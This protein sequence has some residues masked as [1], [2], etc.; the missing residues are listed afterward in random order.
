MERA[1]QGDRGGEFAIEEG[2]NPRVGAQAGV[3]ALSLHRP[4]TLRRRLGA[5]VQFSPRA[6][7][8]AL[9]S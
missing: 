6:L 8:L 2:A 5:E 3:F 1:A 7:V 9:E 4:I